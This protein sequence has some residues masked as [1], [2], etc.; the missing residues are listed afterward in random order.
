MGTTGHRCRSQFKRARPYRDKMVRNTKEGSSSFLKKRSE[1]LLSLGLR[2]VATG[3]PIPRQGSTSG[4][5]IAIASGVGQLG[6]DR[7][8]E[9]PRNRLQLCSWRADRYGR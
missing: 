7:S 6:S 9:H 3:A 4:V 1:K 2:Q 5:T 8:A